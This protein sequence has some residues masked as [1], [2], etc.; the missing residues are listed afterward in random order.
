MFIDSG[1]GD[2]QDSRPAPDHRRASRLGHFEQGL[3]GRNKRPLSAALDQL[4]DKAPVATYGV[5]RPLDVLIAPTSR[6]QSF[7]T[8]I[9]QFQV[10]T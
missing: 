6:A 4:L 9:A 1:A 2:L 3:P 7:E 10:F 5:E 8:S